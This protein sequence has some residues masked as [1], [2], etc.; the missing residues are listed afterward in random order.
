MGRTIRLAAA[1]S[2]DAGIIAA[3]RWIRKP[4]SR[5]RVRQLTCRHDWA[6]TSGVVTSD[7]EW[8]RKCDARRLTLGTPSDNRAAYAYDERPH[9][10]NGT[11]RSHVAGSRKFGVPLDR[12]LGMQ[13]PDGNA[14]GGTSPT[15]DLAAMPP[16]AFSPVRRGGT[17]REDLPR[18]TRK[19]V[20]DVHRMAGERL[21]WRLRGKHA[22][23]RSCLGFAAQTARTGP[24]RN[25]GSAAPMP[26]TRM[27]S[28]AR[29]AEDGATRAIRRC[30]SASDRDATRTEGA[31]GSGL[32]SRQRRATVKSAS[33]SHWPLAA[34]AFV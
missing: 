23:I 24:N 16:D 2:S 22:N 30:G 21:L 11:G 33:A 20:G 29:H 7:T 26:R 12:M 25:T 18:R 10:R 14:H 15:S 31:S 27:L 9:T 5:E 19:R 13:R 3:I 1:L 6:P 28:A 17:L 8:C 32:G 4:S 34:P